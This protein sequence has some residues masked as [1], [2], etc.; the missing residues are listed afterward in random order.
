MQYRSGAQAAE[1][2]DPCGRSGRRV[3]P[4]QESSS[5][6][7]TTTGY[8]SSESATASSAY[9][10]SRCCAERLTAARRFGPALEAALAAVAGEPLRESA[11]RVLIK[12]HLAEGNVSEAIRQY[13]F[14]RTLLQRPA[15][16]RPVPRDGVACRGVDD[17]MTTPVTPR[18]PRCAAMAALPRE[19]TGCAA[20]FGRGRRASPRPCGCGSRGRWT[21]ASADDESEA[22]AS[23][24]EA[25]AIVRS[26][27]EQL[28]RR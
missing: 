8:F 4:L 7:G 24:D 19:R 25:C 6:T 10:R 9:T 1:R 14:Y 12:A 20:S 17:P 21:S 22:A 5:R 26:W 27:L 2:L 16:P 18:S 23:V 3:E 11:H 13:H 15:L 28:Q